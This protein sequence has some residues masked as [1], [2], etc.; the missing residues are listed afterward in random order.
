MVVLGI[1][2]RLFWTLN[3][4]IPF[5]SDEAVVGL[6]AR[7]ILAGERPVFFYGQAY[8]GSLDAGLNALAFRIFDDSITTMRG[9]QICL[10]MILLL[11]VYLL[12]RKIYHS[13]RV[14]WWAVLL[15]SLPP[16][17]VVLYTT[18]TLGGYNEAFILG[19][20]C[21]YLAVCIYQRGLEPQKI[22]ANIPFLILG[23]VSGFGVWAFGFSLLFSLPAVLISVITTWRSHRSAS[24]TLSSIGL[25]LIGTVIGASMWISYAATNGLTG[26]LSELA[27]S[28]IAVEQT[29]FWATTLNH[30]VSFF[31][32]GIPAALG[33]RPPWS[34]RWLFLPLI[35]LVGI[36]WGWVILRWKKSEENKYYWILLSS[37]VILLFVV[38][39]FTPFGVDPSGRYFLPLSLL[40][41]IIGGRVLANL[42]QTRSLHAWGLVTFILIFQLGGSIQA[43]RTSPTGL[44]TQFA[45]FTDIDHSQLYGVMQFLKENNE[46][47]GYTSYWISYPMA[48]LSDEEILLIPRLPYHHDFRYTSRDDRYTP[49][50][51][52]VAESEKT[53]LVT[54]QFPELDARIRILLKD[55]GISW[56]ENRI[57]DFTIF[58]KLT[59][60]LPISALGPLYQPQQP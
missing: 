27:G 26:L 40:L 55:H 25:L 30:L 3:G 57:E 58:F 50:T 54:Y 23:V 10:W 36:L 56:K 46:T 5:N 8:M 32:L 42:E 39:L 51:N 22:P 4:R 21:L 7:H 9:L 41:A 11:S 49:Y 12:G 44:T 31:L 53:S 14:G 29:G 43:E 2:L 15:F 60:P 37:P 45:P 17:N 13:S 6:M 16:V 28:A 1:A 35:P 18:V 48:F 24:S 33:F 20:W 47:I 34:A 59:N 52:R 38:F 19:I